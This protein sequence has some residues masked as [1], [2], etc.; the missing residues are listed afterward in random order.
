MD[1]RW[2]NGHEKVYILSDTI[3]HLVLIF[4]SHRG[5]KWDKSYGFIYDYIQEKDPSLYQLE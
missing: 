4:L 1:G 5:Y 3:E 2:L